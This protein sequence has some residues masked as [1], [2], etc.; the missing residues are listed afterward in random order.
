[1]RTSGCLLL[2][3]LVPGHHLLAEEGKTNSPPRITAYEAKN[4]IDSQAVVFGKVVEIYTT[5]KLVRL[6]LGKPFPQQTF[7]AVIFADKTN[8]FSEF[9]KLKG[10][11]IEVSGK[12][13][14]YREK[15]QIILNSTNQLRI[16][17][18]SLKARPK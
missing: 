17:E 1:M 9:D 8:Q 16:V 3:F 5:D 13:I 11:T 4:H 6:N 2:I 12:I 7:T 14:L 18:S 10:K 15:P